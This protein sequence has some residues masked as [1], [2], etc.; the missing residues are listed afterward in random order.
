MVAGETENIYTAFVVSTVGK[1]PHRGEYPAYEPNEDPHFIN[2][3]HI[4]RHVA[5]LQ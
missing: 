3:L 1:C 2:I 5:P 4:S